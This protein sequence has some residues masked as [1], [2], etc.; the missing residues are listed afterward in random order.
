MRASSVTKCGVTDTLMVYAVMEHGV[1]VV[2]VTQTHPTQ[3][4]E[5]SNQPAIAPQGPHRVT[6]G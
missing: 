1:T 6:P 4:P 5:H 2:W 3:P